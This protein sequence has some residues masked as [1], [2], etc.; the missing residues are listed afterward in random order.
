MEIHQS[1]WIQWEFCKK[2]GTKRSMTQMT[3]GD[4]CSNFCWGHI[5]KS[6]QGLLCP[7]P[8][9]IHH[10]MW[11][12]WPLCQNFKQKVNDPWITFDL[13]SV[14]VT[15]VTLPKDHCVQV[16]WKYIKVSGYSSRYFSKNWT[17][18][19][20][21][22]NKWPLKPLLLRLHVWFYQR[23]TVSKSHENTSNYVDTV[24][25]FQKL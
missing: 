22:L 14:E 9:K 17:N 1:I 20:M 6:T 13:T 16:P 24:T 11:I 5:C 21:T 10:C 4:L 18:R 25:I 8:M 15:C 2:L 12:Q 19:S 7:S 23:I 3:L